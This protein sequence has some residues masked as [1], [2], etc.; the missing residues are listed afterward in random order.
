MAISFL[1]VD[2]EAMRRFVILATY[3]EW[4]LDIVSD[5]YRSYAFSGEKLLQRYG[6]DPEVQQDKLLTSLISLNGMTD[7]RYKAMPQDEYRRIIQ[8]NLDYALGQYKS[9]QRTHVF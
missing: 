8:Q 7:Y 9:S 2:S 5:M 3:P 6:Q 1:P 4:T